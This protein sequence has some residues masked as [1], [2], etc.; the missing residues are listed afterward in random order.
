M[1]VQ[2][3]KSLLNK[4]VN[5]NGNIRDIAKRFEK[6]RIEREREVNDWWKNVL[7]DEERKKYVADVKISG[8]FRMDKLY[9]EYM[10][11]RK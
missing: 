6:R 1:I 11:K 5:M 3:K 4:I 7:S 2:I 9:D 8:S 10:E